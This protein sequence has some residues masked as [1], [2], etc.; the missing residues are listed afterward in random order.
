LTKTF[1]YSGNVEKIHIDTWKG[2]LQA[3]KR[4][5]RYVSVPKDYVICYQGKPRGENEKN[6]HVFV[7][8]DWDG[9]LDR[10]R[11]TNRYVFKMF[12]GAINWISKRQ[13]IISLSTTEEE[14]LIATHGRKEEVWMK[15]LCLGIDFE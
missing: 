11:L 7:D 6:V 12:D 5:F 1:P 9:D 10:Q 2:G 13:K 8:A 14:Y 4:V 15:Q 3:V